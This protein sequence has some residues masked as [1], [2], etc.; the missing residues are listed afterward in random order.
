MHFLRDK[1]E[2]EYSKMLNEF[3]K[4][5]SE[6]QVR[7][8]EKEMLS[9]FQ[10]GVSIEEYSEEEEEEEEQR[11]V[12]SMK[13][14]VERVWLERER[15]RILSESGLLFVE[16]GKRARVF[17]LMA[18]IL[19]LQQDHALLFRDRQ[20]LR[21]LLHLSDHQRQSFSTLQRQSFV[22]NQTQLILQTHRVKH[23]RLAHSAVSPSARLAHTLLYATPAQTR[24]ILHCHSRILT[25]HH[26]HHVRIAEHL[27]TF[28]AALLSLL[29]LPSSLTF[30]SPVEATLQKLY[31]KMRKANP[32]QY[33]VYK[34]SAYSDCL[35]DLYNIE[36]ETLVFPSLQDLVNY[37]AVNS[38]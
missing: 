2:R 17:A 34:D 35:V 3:E 18:R 16:A 22:Q 32:G 21:Y 14:T 20:T 33:P 25:F 8:C 4:L 31:T 27:R 6:H 28:H 7:L 15:Q 10:L 13:R 26:L 23:G 24:R 38:A 9:L 19:T 12:E 1:D 37:Q 11:G 36:K 5:K 30:R 29:A